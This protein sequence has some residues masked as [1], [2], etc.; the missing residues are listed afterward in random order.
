MDNNRGR[1]EREAMTENRGREKEKRKKG[2][3]EKQIRRCQRCG[4]RCENQRQLSM[5]KRRNTAGLKK[6]D[7]LVIKV[8]WGLMAGDPTFPS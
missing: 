4:I 7:K 6:E 1:E 3:S 2:V 5:R 8:G